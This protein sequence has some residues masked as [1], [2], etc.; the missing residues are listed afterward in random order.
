MVKKRTM[1]IDEMIN[2]YQ[3]GN[4]T[5][6]IAK[7]ANVSSR[8]VRLVLAENN[9]E[10]RP[11]GHWKR[12]YTLNEDYF[13]TWSNNMAYILGFFVADGVVAKDSPYISFSQKDKE[14]LEDI[15][16]EL[17][18][19]QPLSQNK[20]T[21]VYLFTINSKILKHDLMELHGITPNK[22]LN[23]K[24]PFVPDKYLSH[25]IRGYFDGDGCI[26]E[27]RNFVNIV[28]GSLEFMEVLFHILKE[29]K[30]NP[31]LKNFGKHYRI[32]LSGYA[33]IK[34]FS[35]WIYNDKELLLK[36]KFDR[37]NKNILTWENS[38]KSH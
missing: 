4:S 7:Q 9:I 2:L 36:R 22:S 27:N 38:K 26:Y 16:K 25:F 18:S 10:K 24:F 37:F 1:E 6:E 8:Y 14:I 31:I 23:V 30:L 15:K 13:K 3:E 28:G 29:N 17:N 19:E 11:F 20:K 21:G 32:Y 33:D 35:T 5:T 34:R 12:Q